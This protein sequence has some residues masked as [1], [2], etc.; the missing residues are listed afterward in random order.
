MDNNV[1]PRS[2]EFEFIEKA[3]VKIGFDK[4]LPLTKLSIKLHKDILSSCL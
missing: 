1:L 4:S 3:F 2:L